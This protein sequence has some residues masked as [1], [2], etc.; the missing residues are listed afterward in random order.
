V[1]MRGA[2][3][4]V[5][6]AAAALLASGAASP[7]APAAAGE[8]PVAISAGS[9]HTCALTTLGAVKCWGVDSADYTDTG[10]CCYLSDSPVPE[11]I[12]GLPSGVQALTAGGDHGCALV[13][14]SGK[15]WGWTDAG[16]LGNPDAQ[17]ICGSDFFCASAVDVTGLTG[18]AAFASGGAHSCAVTLAG[19]ALCWGL[20]SNGEV[21]NGTTSEQDQPVLVSGLASGVSAIAAG[22]AQTCALMTGGDVKCWG[23]NDR[24]QLGDGT[25][26]ERHVPTP[27]PGLHHVVT[28]AAGGTHTCALMT[29]GGVKCWGANHHGQLG[30]GTTTDRHTPTSV[31]GLTGVSAL[32]AGGSHT[33]ALKAGAVEC[34]GANSY[35]QLGDGTTTDHSVPKTVPGLSS[36]AAITA[37]T[38]HTCALSAARSVECWGA[39]DNGQLGDGTTFE[40]LSPV[41]VLWGP[42]CEVPHV[43]GKKL[44]AAEAALR[45]KG[46][47][48]GRVYRAFARHQK[49]TVLDSY[50]GAYSYLPQGG[51]VDVLV[52]KGRRPAS[53]FRAPRGKSMRAVDSERIVSADGRTAAFPMTHKGCDAIRIWRVGRAPAK[54]RTPCDE[55]GVYTLGLGGTRILWPTYDAANLVYCHLRTATLAHPRDRQIT[56]CA[57]EGDD[58]DIENVVGQGSV[59]AFNAD[60]TVYSVV[61]GK[62]PF[63][64][65]DGVTV[66]SVWGRRISVLEPDGSVGIYTPS[67]R[68][69]TRL[70]SDA[71][72]AVLAAGKLYTE[73]GGN[74]F[75]YDLSTGLPPLGVPLKAGP[76]ASLVRVAH[77]IALTYLSNEI[78]LTRLSSGKD[79][80][81][82]A[83]AA[84]LTPKGLFYSTGKRVVFV[85]MRSVL[86]LFR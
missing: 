46:C 75:V 35:G 20:N 70:G 3:V 56:F 42:V 79:V 85:R 23:A 71:T 17:D 43:G 48:V 33:C 16:Q 59:L 76:F 47:T 38:A 27:V 34:W 29:G 62:G 77:G 14:G 10:D 13:G 73:E 83:T 84:D 30:D 19:G 57:D 9:D 55:S 50:P 25:T 22:G 65:A 8:Q 6:V 68:L 24:G 74:V 21:G 44:A 28:L 53:K 37:G 5:L 86:R 12:P 18:A 4:A 52:S 66:T 11:N 32:T 36:V 1:P 49:G 60:T 45:A 63:I 2:L 58:P 51:A 41:P 72:Q 40:R 81:L 54:V 39:N 82:K 7:A 69:V 78:H 15:C 67:G 31:T 61:R 80:A 26:T 64:V